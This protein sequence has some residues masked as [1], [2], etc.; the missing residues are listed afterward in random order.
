[1]IAVAEKIS[2]NKEIFAIENVNKTV[3]AKVVKVSSAIDL[4]NKHS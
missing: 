1:M 3:T 2:K 4:R